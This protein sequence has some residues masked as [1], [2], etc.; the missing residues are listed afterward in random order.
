MAH[1]IYD[2]DSQANNNAARYDNYRSRGS[3]GSGFNGGLA[4]LAGVILV[5]L[6]YSVDLSRLRGDLNAA[7]RPAAGDITT[8]GYADRRYVDADN[9]NMREQPTSG[10]RVK[11]VLP[12][13]TN[14]TLLGDS[15][16]NNNGDVWVKVSVE[17]YEGIQ[18]GWVIL[19]YLR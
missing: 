9:L 14:V 12:R 7:I 16:Q 17:T 10:A 4:L 11:F 18:D 5:V 2:N 19:N 8:R 13:G 15:Q 6:L 3:D 1:I